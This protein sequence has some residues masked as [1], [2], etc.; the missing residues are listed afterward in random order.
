LVAVV[1]LLPLSLPMYD[2]EFDHGGGSCGGPAAVAVAA[3]AVVEA[4]EDNLSAKAAGN[5]NVDGRLTACVG[6]IGRQT[7]TQQP[8]KERQRGSGAH[9]NCGS[10]AAARQLRRWWQRE[11]A[12][13]VAAWRWR[14]GGGSATARRWWQLGGGAAAAHSAM[15]AAQ[16]R[17]VGSSLA[18][19]QQRDVGGSLAAALAAEAHSVTAAAR[20]HDVGGSLMVAQR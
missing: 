6:K 9:R 3:T 5:E 14:G 11:S 10:V 13:L 4:V 16:H 19:A 20:H 17:D 15:A 18:A 2:D 12:T 1:V 8:T 7:K